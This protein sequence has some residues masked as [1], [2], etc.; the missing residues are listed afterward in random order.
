MVGRDQE[1]GVVH[2]FLASVEHDP[3]GLL[4]HGEAGIGKTTLWNAG[5]EATVFNPRPPRH[6]DRRHR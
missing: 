1:L 6:Y 5:L 3:A 4:L 2:E